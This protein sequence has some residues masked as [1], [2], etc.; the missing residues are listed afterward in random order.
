MSD[1]EKN[2]ESAHSAHVAQIDGT[3][4]EVVQGAAERAEFDH[5]L[6]IKNAVRYYRWAI[7]WCLAL[8]MTV[9]MEGYDTILIGNF[10]AFPEFQKKYGRFVGV[11][12]T[13]QSGYQLKPA[14]QSGIG[15]GAGVGA[16][17]GALANGLLVNKFGQK[18]TV[19]GA[20]VWLSA[21]IFMTFFAPNIE[22]LLAGQILCGLPWG[23]FATSAPAY[24]S[25]LLP[26]TLRIYFT[27][28]TNMCFIIGQLIA[29]GILRACL[30]RND[31][32]GFRIP[33]A[34]Q[35][36][37]PLFLFPTLWFAPESPWHLVRQGKHTEAEAVLR[38]LQDPDAPIDVKQTLA[39]II[40]TNDLEQELSVGTSYKD[41]FKGF[42]LRRTEI[43]C[44]CFAGQVICGS[45]FVSVSTP[46]SSRRPLTNSTRRIPQLT[47]GAKLAFPREQL[48]TST[49][50]APPWL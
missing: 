40:Y 48:T 21:A 49:S 13:T 14:W 11:T 47:S 12:K 18:N 42:E 4:K 29:A 28:W 15:N 46:R 10:Y 43:A 44:L 22:T 1:I 41:C 50:W 39:T 34:L 25:E 38:R 3:K 2:E 7:I 37:W 9:V 36:L 8:S 17:F 32:W 26:M 6:T 31:E 20:L 27:S 23:V 16:F 24:A 45:Q 35:W 5:Q 30:D 33:F 19:L